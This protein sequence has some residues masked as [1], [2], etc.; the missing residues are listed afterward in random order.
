VLGRTIV[1]T[2]LSL[3]YTYRLPKTMYAPRES[4]QRI[5]YLGVYN[6]PAGK[7]PGG[8]EKGISGA[9]G[10]QGVRLNEG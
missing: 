6:D 2:L 9:F 4:A 10:Q 7:R 8:L 1:L 5:L 3:R